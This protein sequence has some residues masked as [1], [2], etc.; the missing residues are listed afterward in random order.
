MDTATRETFD[1][2]IKQRFAAAGA[3][4][5]G[6]KLEVV[7]TLRQ[8]AQ[9]GK[10]PVGTDQ[11]A[12][13]P[14]DNQAVRAVLE[15]KP[16]SIGGTSVVTG[17]RGG[18]AGLSTPIKI[19]LL[20][21]IPLV[22]LIPLL[23]IK[24]KTRRGEITPTPEAASLTSTPFV[25]EIPSPTPTVMATAT[26]TGTATSVPTPTPTPTPFNVSL[27][28]ADDVAPGGNDPASVEFAGYSFVLSEGAVNKSGLWEPQ[29]S[30]WLAGTEVRRVVA[31]PYA[32]ELAT[33][34]NRLKT[35]DELKL[36]LRSGEVVAYRVSDV[37]RIKRHQ[38]EVLSEKLPS[39]VVMLYGERSG[40]RTVAVA[41]A[42]QR[43]EDFLIYTPVVITGTPTTL[44]VTPTP[45]TGE[46]ITTMIT[47]T[48]TLT[49]TAAGLRLAVD[50]CHQA[51]QIGSMTPPR[52]QNFVVCDVTLTAIGQAAATY[53][54]DALAITD[55]KWIAERVAWWPESVAAP[56]SIGNGVL[57][58]GDAISGQVAGTVPV[59]EGIP[60]LGGKTLPV[61]VWEQAG[62]RYIMKLTEFVERRER[63]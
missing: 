26:M 12:R 6:Q 46:P 13:L 61:L 31:V 28:L 34:V 41:E 57:Q 25:T 20:A 43:P 4:T 50:N 54:S 15:G 59:V 48:M 63:R 37:K 17:K 33:A 45:F 22:L 60:L 52:G 38:I 21:A 27:Y 56:G 55:Y 5:L 23:A 19:S 9:Q 35:G 29:G 47:T 30:E 42:V 44:T 3:I 51:T 40:E 11:V 18:L 10:V 2:Y 62:V 14:T 49:N 39:L 32:P 8:E 58:P 16:V 24:V 1:R 7:R 36:R 53:N